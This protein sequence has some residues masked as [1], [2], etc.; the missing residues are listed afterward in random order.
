MPQGILLKKRR[1]NPH[2]G[3]AAIGRALRFYD[4]FSARCKSFCAAGGGPGGQRL[5]QSE[6]EDEKPCIL[7]VL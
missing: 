3:E 7:V 6:P 2:V 1:L 5:Q 4:A